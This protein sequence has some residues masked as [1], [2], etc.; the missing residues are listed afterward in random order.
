MLRIGSAEIGSEGWELPHRVIASTSPPPLSPLNGVLLLL[1][2]LLLSKG[3]G[4][5]GEWL[6]WWA[7]SGGQEVQG[8]LKGKGSFILSASF[9]RIG[10]RHTWVTSVVWARLGE[11]GRGIESSSPPLLSAHSSS[12]SSSASGNGRQSSKKS[13]MPD[14]SWK[15]HILMSYIFSQ[16]LATW[17][18]RASFEG[19]VSARGFPEKLIALAGLQGGEGRSSRWPWW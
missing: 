3:G 7:G 17:Y 12:S 9:F 10:N 4:E 13:M 5:D 16:S 15:G 11:K 6:S 14:G 19:P 8:N 2:L 1:L 18:V